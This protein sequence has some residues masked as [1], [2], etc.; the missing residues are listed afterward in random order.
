MTRTQFKKYYRKEH[1]YPPA[2]WRVLW[3][4]F[5]QGALGNHALWFWQEP[6]WRKPR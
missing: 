2:P 3:Q 5:K 4:A 6:T 1:G